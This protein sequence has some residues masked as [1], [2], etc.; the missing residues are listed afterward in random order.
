MANKWQERAGEFGFPWKLFW[1]WTL[2]IVCVVV[3]L[4]LITGAVGYGLGWFGAA[5]QIVSPENFRVQFAKAYGLYEGLPALDQNIKQA[6]KSLDDFANM[7]GGDPTKF[8]SLDR[9]EYA[10]LSATHDGFVNEYNRRVG[11]FNA[12]M[13]NVFE[14]KVAGP[15]DLPKHLP[16]WGEK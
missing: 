4:S 7:R 9:E 2:I 10:R 6:Q 1:K 14:G 12:Q 13:R 8:M 16:F 3:A 15:P 5:K 11:E